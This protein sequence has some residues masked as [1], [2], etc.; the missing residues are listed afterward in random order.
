[1]AKQ[2]FISVYASFETEED[3][4]K[5]AHEHAIKQSIPNG[6]PVFSYSNEDESIYRDKYNDLIIEMRRENI[7]L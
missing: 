6:G 7:K 1:M 3:A 4:K 5:W 2:H